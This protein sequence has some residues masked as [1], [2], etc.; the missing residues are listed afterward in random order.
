MEGVGTAWG[1]IWA[2]LGAPGPFW[3]RSKW[4]F[5]KALVQ[6]GLQ[7]ALWRDLGWV[8]GGFGTDFGKIWE[9]FGKVLG[10]VWEGFGGVLGGLRGGFCKVFG[11]KNLLKAYKN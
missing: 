10:G 5:F 8:W 9:S 3:G 2:L 7:E 11:G 1:P 4:N 6:N